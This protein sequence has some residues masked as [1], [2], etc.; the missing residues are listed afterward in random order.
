MMLGHMKEQGND[1][2]SNKNASRVNWLQR[3]KIYGLLGNICTKNTL[4]GICMLQYHAELQ[5]V[6]KI[7]HSTHMVMDAARDMTS[8]CIGIY[9]AI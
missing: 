7:F 8:M 3:V 1:R 2:T 5:G 4:V 9:A 6:T